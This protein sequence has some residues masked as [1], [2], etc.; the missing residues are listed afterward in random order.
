MDVRAPQRNWTLA[1]HY[2]VPADVEREQLRSVFELA[3]RAPRDVAIISQVR[4]PQATESSGLAALAEKLGLRKEPPAW[5]G[6]R[7][8]DLSADPV[9]LQESA[10]SAPPSPQALGGALADALES[11]PSRHTAIVLGGHGAGYLGTK[12]M[13]LNEVAEALAQTTRRTGHKTD[14]LILH[15]CL[16]G[17]LE[18]LR[19]LAPYAHYALV[20]ENS[21]APQALALDEKAW[22]GDARTVG[23]AL[24]QA[25]STGRGVTTQ[26]LIDLSRVEE[27]SQSLEQLAPELEKDPEK[28]ARAFAQPFPLG[29]S[30]V[31][32]TTLGVSDLGILLH[33]LG[34]DP[35]VEKCHALLRETVV[36][37]KA[38]GVDAGAEG[39]SIR[40]GTQGFSENA[41][42]ERTDMPRWAHMLGVLAG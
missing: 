11:H 10:S 5:V 7:T 17:N 31:A 40:T 33:A 9:L 21:Q 2:D 35:Q 20:S 39:L 36:A 32:Q 23:N 6:T 26:S 27:L 13:S 4:R 12:G 1:A 42:V 25:A 16:M 14:L 28:T 34:D 22:Q 8:Y 18:A 15:S 24:V 19:P 3:D 41:Y 30:E 37:N 29:H 38:T